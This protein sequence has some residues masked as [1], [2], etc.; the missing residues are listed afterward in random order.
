MSER[1]NELR[2]LR[3]LNKASDG[4]E[5]NSIALEKLE[6]AE[7]AKA[8]IEK[9][10]TGATLETLAERRKR[11]AKVRREENSRTE[12]ALPSRAVLMEDIRDLG[13]A[14]GLQGAGLSRYIGK[15]KSQQSHRESMPVIS[16][17][18]IPFPSSSSNDPG[19]VVQSSGGHARKASAASSSAEN[20]GDSTG[21]SMHDSGPPSP[22]STTTVTESTKARTAD[23]TD[24]L[25]RVVYDNAD[26]LRADRSLRADIV[27]SL[28]ALQSRLEEEENRVRDAEEERKKVLRTAEHR[29]EGS[30]AILTVLRSELKALQQEEVKL[31][32]SLADTR[33]HIDGTSF[34]VRDLNNRL[35]Q[36]S[37]EL[38]SLRSERTR[39]R[40]KVFTA[41]L[42]W[43]LTLS[44][45]VLM[46]LSFLRLRWPSFGGGNSNSA[47]KEAKRMETAARL[48]QLAQR[49][50]EEERTLLADIAQEDLDSEEEAEAKEFAALT[51]AAAAAVVPH[52][53]RESSS[54]APSAV[55]GAAH[56]PPGRMASE[57]DVGE[58]IPFSLGRRSERSN[59]VMSMLSESSDLESMHARPP[60]LRRQTTTTH[61]G[62]QERQVTS[63]P[64]AM[65][66]DSLS[67][68]AT[69]SSHAML[70]SFDSDFGATL[71]GKVDQFHSESSG[72]DDAGGGRRGN[73]SHR[74]DAVRNDEVSGTKTIGESAAPILDEGTK[75]FLQ[76]FHRH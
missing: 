54:S 34:D 65:M 67:N 53:L 30:E 18:T 16:R 15:L 8:A 36:M 47:K 9:Q 43:L 11:L 42:S 73:E 44:A 25:A 69:S 51:S 75:R 1:A 56:P 7:D 58:D 23:L 76:K 6:R 31:A 48:Q 26:L 3:M 70:T 40:T 66:V 74:S 61:T 52:K 72:E 64:I 62:Q 20:E 49:V 29:I 46:M 50:E 38:S 13:G 55:P 24:S 22:H 28:R 2:F 37:L 59:T 27:E 21:R 71:L 60:R 33:A 4:S 35:A 63:S 10:Y 41:V 45:S 68:R 39:S 5:A 32:R 57:N 12:A 19:T 14:N 17:S